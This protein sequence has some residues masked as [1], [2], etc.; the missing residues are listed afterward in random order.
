VSEN[1]KGH[2]VKE[3]IAGFDLGGTYLKYGLGTL[4]GTVILNGK[5]PS[6]GDESKEAIFS[7]FF[8]CIEKLAGEAKYRN[9]KLVGIGVGSPGAIDFDK[10]RLKGKTPNLPNWG[11]ADLRT[12]ITSKCKLPLW[13][14]ND[15]NVMVLAESR[16]GA[17]KGHQNVIAITLGT[18]IGG[19][20]LI[21]N[22]IYRG[23]NYAGAELGHVSVVF[24]GLTCDCGGRGCI[25][26]YASAPA[27]IRNY[28][29]KLTKMG[30]AIPDRVT[31]EY[32]FEQANKGSEAANATIDETCEYLGSFLAGMANIF[33]PE[34]IVIG[35]GVSHAGEDFIN[36][37][38]KSVQERAMEPNLVG[39]KLVN[40]QLG[41]DAGLVGA[42][43]LAA[44]NYA[45]TKTIISD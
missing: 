33:N 13:A 36:R 29:E 39:L 42:I 4:E 17:A 1:N 26:K 5:K 15:A 32:I 19:G 14:D 28:L 38:W 31:T 34:V 23:V 21:N 11:N 10:G 45:A 2:R 22:Q 37:I 3:F 44:E 12:T 27:M 8:E 43:S 40:A 6:R 7:V 16:K 9:G 20:L 25:E 30:T 24:N 18:G 35:G 41:N